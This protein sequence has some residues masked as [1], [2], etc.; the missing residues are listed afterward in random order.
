MKVTRQRVYKAIDG[1]RKYQ[2]ILWANTES[3]GTHAPL[4]FFAYIRSYVNEAMEELCRRNEK[5]ARVVA[6]HI[7]RKVAGLAVS[8]MEKNG[9]FDRDLGDLDQA[10]ELHDVNCRTDVGE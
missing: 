10:C 3:Q 4:E 6:M 1:E 5:S 9:V 8:C 2:D 7:M